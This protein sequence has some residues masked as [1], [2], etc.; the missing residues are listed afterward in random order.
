MVGDIENPFFATAARGLTDVF[1]A[2]GY[3]VLLANADEDRERERRAV[4][5]SARH[6]GWT[7]WWSCRRPVPELAELVSSGRSAGAARPRVAGSPPTR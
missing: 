1:D 7:A 6:A 2:H 3:T 5:R 4:G